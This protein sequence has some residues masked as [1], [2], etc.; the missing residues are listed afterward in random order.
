[1]DGLGARVHLLLIPLGSC[2]PLL[3]FS[4]SVPRS[5]HGKGERLALHFTIFVAT[6][7]LKSLVFLTSSSFNAP[8]LLLEGPRRIYFQP[9]TPTPEHGREMKS[10]THTEERDGESKS[11]VKQEGIASGAMRGREERETWTLCARAS[12]VVCVFARKLVLLL[13]SRVF[14]FFKG[15]N[16]ARKKRK[17]AECNTNGR[18]TDCCDFNYL[19]SCP[20]SCERRPSHPPCISL[21]QVFILRL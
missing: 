20:P 13:G 10:N 6:H 4:H 7:L 9:P 19:S 8:S 17:S 3:S 15:A 21:S 1:M 2:P 14:T 5:R 16:A 12:V 18:C 11:N